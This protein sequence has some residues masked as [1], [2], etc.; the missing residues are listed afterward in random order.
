MKVLFFTYDFPYP[1]NSGGKARAYN[2]LKYASK[3]VEITLFSFVRPDF[4]TAHI[5]KIKEVG[6]KQVEVFPRR[7][8]RDGK[9]LKAVFTRASLFQT[10][11]YDISVKKRLIDFVEKENISLL[12]FE[13]FYTAFYLDTYFTGKGIKQIYGS[14]NIEPQLYA[15]Y[16]KYNVQFFL[17]PFFFPQIRKLRTEEQAMNKLADVTLAVTE[18]EKAYFQK[19]SGKPVYVIENGVDLAQFPFKSRPYTEQVNILFVGNFKYFPNTDAVQFFYHEVLRKIASDTIT[20]TIIG[21][22][23]SQFA[24]LDRRIKT[25]EFVDSIQDA[26][27]AA[28]IF[29]SPIKIGGGTNFKILE[30]MATGVPVVTFSERVRDIGAVNDRDVLTGDTGEEFRQQ[31]LRLI[32]KPE[33]RQKLAKNARNIIEEKFAWERIGTNLNKI[34]KELDGQR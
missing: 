29:I 19:L 1:T 9:N 12:H 27:Y 18:S 2:L 20:F 7:K 17:K 24:A 8:V 22:G 23:S 6:V 25:V 21:K 28:D 34:W 30:A 14:E 11:Y 13:S 15:D 31:V 32:D 3:G 26:Y 16:V 5:E 4:D 10:L 33:L